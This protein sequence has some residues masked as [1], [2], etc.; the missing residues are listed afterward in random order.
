MLDVTDLNAFY[1][2]SHILQGVNMTINQ[3]RKAL[4]DFGVATFVFQNGAVATIEVTWT[5]ECSGLTVGFQLVGTEGQLHA[6]T[7]MKGSLPNIQTV[8][9][10]AA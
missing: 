4:E 10:V 3:F 2:K 7:I 9:N 5:A 6:D 8:S 1:G